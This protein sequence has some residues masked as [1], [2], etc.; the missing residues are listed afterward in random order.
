MALGNL[1]KFGGFGADGALP[2]P[3]PPPPVAG[4]TGAAAGFGAAAPAA[5][6]GVTPL[7]V[8]AL[9]AAFRIAALPFASPGLI[10]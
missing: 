10:V 5:G 4:L 3:P 8:P 7:V 6:L 2:P 9:S 1:L